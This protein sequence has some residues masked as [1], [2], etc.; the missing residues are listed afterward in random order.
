MKLQTIISA[1]R[2]DAWMVECGC[3]TGASRLHAAKRIAT[4]DVF[5]DCTTDNVKAER[6]PYGDY[7]VTVL[8]PGYIPRMINVPNGEPLLW[9]PPEPLPMCNTAG[10]RDVDQWGFWI[11]ALAG[12][13]CALVLIWGAHACLTN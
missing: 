9:M 4:I 1:G 13:V 11:G 12:F 2:I 6:L 8:W 5:T 10:D 3:I 7:R